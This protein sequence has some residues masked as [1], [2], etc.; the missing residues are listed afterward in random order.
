MAK[1]F[2]CVFQSLC[3][4]KQYSSHANDTNVSFVIHKK[5]KE[6]EKE[7]EKENEKE[8]EKESEK[9]NENEKEKES[10]SQAAEG[11]SDVSEFGSAAWQKNFIAFFNRCVEGSNIPCIRTLTAERIEALRKLREAIKASSGQMRNTEFVFKQATRRGG[12]RY[13]GFEKQKKTPK[14]FRAP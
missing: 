4:G 14:T 7:R 6:N 3:R 12:I 1:K 9:E 2:Y 5:E 11:N 8:R 10:S 13:A